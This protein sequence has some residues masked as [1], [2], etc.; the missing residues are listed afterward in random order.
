MDLPSKALSNA[1]LLQQKLD[2][3]R[4]FLRVSMEEAKKDEALP[5]L[6]ALEKYGLQEFVV[7][8]ASTLM[9]LHKTGKMDVAVDKTM[10]HF[11]LKDTPEVKQRLGRY[12]QFLVDFLSQTMSE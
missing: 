2:N 11:C 12:Y 10:E 1:E 6:E 9:P 4:G 3:Y 5:R 7:F 8:G